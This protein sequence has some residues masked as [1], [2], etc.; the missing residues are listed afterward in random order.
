MRPFLLIIFFILTTGLCYGVAAK[1]DKSK[2]KPKAVLQ[3]DT[4]TIGLRHYDSAAL[5]AYS[6][7][8]EFQYKEK[9]VDISWW[10]R[11]WA[12]VWSILAWIKSFFDFSSPKSQ[13]ALDIIWLI[14][15]YL[16]LAAGVGA[17]IFFILKAAGINML[18]IFRRNPAAAPIPYSEYFED[19]HQINFDEEIENAVSKHNY[20]FAVRLLYLKCL[21]QLSDAGL[22][23]WQIDKTNSAY[24]DEL[25]NENQRSAFKMLT[26]Q[27]EY[28]WY[29]EFLIDEPIYKNINM[30]FNDFNKKAA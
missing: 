4:S 1:Q 17:L 13:G 7:L 19:I 10:T 29:G 9:G 8:P 2:P 28:V 23:A 11:F 16:L 5:K 30:S 20:R 6:K 25:A 27:F 26:H 24:I 12:W 14:V 15:R 22:I 18:G 3:I 21:K